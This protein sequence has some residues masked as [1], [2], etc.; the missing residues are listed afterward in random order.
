MKFDLEDL[1]PG[2]WFDFPDGEGRICIRSLS[3]EDADAIT[4]ATS[5]KEAEYVEGTRYEY[6]VVDDD[7]LSDMT[8]DSC[9]VGWE[10]LMDSDGKDIPC[11][12][13]MKKKL[14]RGSPTFSRIVRRFLDKLRKAETSFKEKERKNL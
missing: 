14:M 13:D 6:D 9:I 8:W 5:K 3:S 10:G 4:R 12:P 7:K 11:T 1:N 2:T